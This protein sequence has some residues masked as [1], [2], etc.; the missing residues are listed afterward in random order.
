MELCIQRELREKQEREKQEIRLKLLERERERVLAQALQSAPV[1][2]ADSGVIGGHVLRIDDKNL[3]CVEK[4]DSLCPIRLDIDVDGVKIRD[5]F[6][7][8]VHEKSI[9]P[10]KFA[11]ILCE[12]LHLQTPHHIYINQIVKVINEHIED[13]YDHQPSRYENS[14]PDEDLQSKG[15]LSWE[16]RITIKL[17]ITIEGVSLVDQIEWDIN[18]A[19]SSPEHFADHLVTELG[20]CSEF[21][22]AIAHSIREQV[23]IY[24]KSLLILDHPF[25]DTPVDDD[26]LAA[27]FLEPVA[28]KSFG[29]D[30]HNYFLRE[31]ASRDAFSPL[32]LL[33]RELE[34]EKVEK[35]KERD[36][37]RALPDRDIPRTI[38]TSLSMAARLASAGG[39]SNYSAQSFTNRRKTRA[40]TATETALG[41]REGTP[42]G[43]EPQAIEN[44]TETDVTPD[45]FDQRRFEI[46]N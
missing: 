17:D 9:T 23:Q 32:L 21:R 43:G 11:E 6:T 13:F 44:S 46:G 27:C 22:T 12:D 24:T 42:L 39:S 4:D 37:R 8:N 41:N 36:A 7:W 19:N 45:G 31:P 26:E 28:P 2:S 14:S 25:D 3:N 20:L 29:E 34:A 40:D 33:S 15:Y 16:W 18:G 30:S 1:Q 35:D 5:N 38:R 10:E